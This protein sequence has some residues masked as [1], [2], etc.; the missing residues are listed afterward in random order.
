M[1]RP[2]ITVVT[3]SLNQG[4]FL[5]DTILSVIGQHYEPLEYIVIDGGSTDESVEILGKYAPY[6]AHWV[7][8]KDD[9]QASALNKGFARATGDVLAWL[10]SDDMYLPGALAH[11]A[12]G[13]DPSGAEILFGNC[14]HVGKE[15]PR[16]H[17]SD[18]RKAH[19]GR[20][21][22]LADYIVQPS[23]FW[24]RKAWLETGPLDESLDFAFDWEWFLRA[25]RK[26]VVLRPDD[27]YL[28]LYRMH[29]GHKTG[30]GGERRRNEL[31]WIYGRYAGPEYE[32]LFRRC[33]AHRSPLAAARK[34]LFRAGMS[35]VEASALKVAFPTLFR[36][37]TRKEVGDLVTML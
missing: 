20:D 7:S 15:L 29:P 25:R 18:V 22:A 6:L 10:N 27:R 28:S 8:E 12:A 35:R 11:I 24:T 3:P 14:L 19:A 13:L 30:T 4:R 23:A 17:G 16:V 9:G 5:E 34:W 32:R 31:A 36:G 26:G 1:T 37:F 33:C 2:K 21:L